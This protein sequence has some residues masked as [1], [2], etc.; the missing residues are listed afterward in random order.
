[1]LTPPKPDAKPVRTE[2]VSLRSFAD[3]T[4]LSLNLLRK[5]CLQGRILGARKHVLTKQWWVYPPAIIM[6]SQKRW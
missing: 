5:Y 2:P 4:G 1:M 3:A 6:P